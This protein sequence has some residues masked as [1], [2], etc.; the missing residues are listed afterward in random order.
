MGIIT[1]FTTMC[2]DECLFVKFV[3][4]GTVDYVSTSLSGRKINRYWIEGSFF[5][6]SNGGFLIIAFQHEIKDVRG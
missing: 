3:Y 5:W 1:L 2:V 6:Q 4:K